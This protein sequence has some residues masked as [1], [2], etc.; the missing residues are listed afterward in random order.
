MGLAS[1]SVVTATDDNTAGGNDDRPN[2]WI[3]TRQAST[4]GRHSQSPIHVLTIS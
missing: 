1:T 2:Q 3:G 4:Q